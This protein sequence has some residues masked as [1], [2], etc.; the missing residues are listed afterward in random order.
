MGPRLA[1]LP[2]SVDVAAVTMDLDRCIKADVALSKVYKLT[3]VIE[4]VGAHLVPHSR[5]KFDHTG[6]VD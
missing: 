2:S 6:A 3:D 5:P 1:T 4:L